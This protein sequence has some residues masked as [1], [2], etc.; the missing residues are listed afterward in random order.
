[1]F[2]ICSKAHTGLNFHSNERALW[3]KRSLLL[4]SEPTQNTPPKGQFRCANNYKNVYF[5]AICSDGFTALV[6]L[7]HTKV[8]KEKQRHISTACVEGC[9]TF[10]PRLARM[11]VK[12]PPVAN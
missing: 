9:G 7:H 6:G 5:A 10:V 4:I 3:L 1:M 8:L 2:E 12:Q 11:A